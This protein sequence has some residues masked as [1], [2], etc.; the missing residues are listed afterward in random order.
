MQR[1]RES[2]PIFPFREDLMRAVRDNRA[3]VIVGETGSG[4]TTQI[5]QY[6]LDEGFCKPREV[7][8]ALFFF[9]LFFSIFTPRGG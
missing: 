7:A 8:C 5:A 9:F 3:I 1:I 2:L 4:K 6:L